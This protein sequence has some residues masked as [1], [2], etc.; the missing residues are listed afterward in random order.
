[1]PPKPATAGTMVWRGIR[2]RC[3]RCG[4]KGIFASYFTLKERCPVCG[5]RFVREAGAFTGVML[6]NVTATFV[7]MF[8]SLISY[9]FWRGVTGEDVALW[10]F[11]VACLA[12]AAVVP[13]VFYPFAAS[14]WASMDLAMRPLDPAE[15]EDADAH[16]SVN[17][18]R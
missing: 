9:V 6:M 10:P 8:L 4:A 13:I 12:F 3:G 18:P 17:R 2:R 1:M 5:Y 15:L 7:L 11:A 16:A 14:L